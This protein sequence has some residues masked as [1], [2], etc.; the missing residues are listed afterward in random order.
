MSRGT[1][2]SC[3]SDHQP[4]PLHQPP[5]VRLSTQ[6]RPSAPCR[7]PPGTGRGETEGGRGSGGGEGE[8]EEV[9]LVEGGASALGVPVN[10]V[11]S[12]QFYAFFL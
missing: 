9:C 12:H 11:I 6:P 2:S 8:E 4:P 1:S 10:S 3:S 5:A 7:G